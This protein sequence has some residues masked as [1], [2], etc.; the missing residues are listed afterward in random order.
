[1]TAISG[2]ATASFIYDAFGRRV[3]KTV[4][5]ASTQFLYDESNPVQELQSGSPSANLLTGLNVDQYFTRT[6]SNGAMAFLVDALGSTIGLANSA[7]SLVTSYA[8]Q[9]FGATTVTGATNANPYQFAGQENDNSMLYFNRARYYGPTYQRFIAQD[10]LDF[11][12]GGPNLYS[13]VLNNPITFVDPSGLS[14]ATPMPSEPPSLPTPPAG[15]PTPTLRPTPQPN[16]GG[17]VPP[18]TCPGCPPIG[19]WPQPPTCG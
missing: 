1:M 2:G 9:P 7:G 8:Y 5:G 15:P 3:Q 19:L 4:A 12:G 11:V 18:H 10:P 17:P 6:D 16:P 14:T 13:Y